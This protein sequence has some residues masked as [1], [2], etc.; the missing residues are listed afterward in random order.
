MHN[1]A[2][3]CFG[4][5]IFNNKGGPDHGIQHAFKQCVRYS[6]HNMAATLID[7]PVNDNRSGNESTPKILMLIDEMES[8]AAGGTERQIL[9]IAALLRA[10]GFETVIATLRGT[11]WLTPEVAGCPVHHANVM[12]LR[13]RSS[14]RELQK[15]QQWMRKERFHIL[16]TFFH[17]SNC[18]GSWLASRAG[19][20]ALVGGRRNLGTTIPLLWKALLRLSNRRV[21]QFHANCEA[22]GQKAIRAEGISPDR[23]HIVYNGIDLTL[24]EGLYQ[25]RRSMR[26]RLGLRPDAIL[27]GMVSGLRPEKGVGD[28]LE[29]ARQMIP[30]AP[31]AH[32]LI[33]GGGELQAALQARVDQHNLHSRIQ[34]VGAQNDVLPYLAAMDV[35]VLSS[36]T[37]GLS[38]SLLEYMAAGL[39]VIATNVGGNREAVGDAGI[40]VPARNPEALAAAMLQM[41]S[42]EW[43]SEFAG[44]SRKQVQRFSLEAAGDRLCSLYSH[45]I[46]QNLPHHFPA[47]VRQSRM[48]RNNG[49][50]AHMKNQNHQSNLRRRR[51]ACIP[52][53]TTRSTELA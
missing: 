49:S 17:E 5:R 35:G 37:E 12:S 14:W 33:V 52:S 25:Y 6:A 2:N 41:Q 40:L 29:A 27:Y 11:A 30:S 45:L 26:Q 31:R 16:T 21:D 7:Q 53:Q 43:R 46:E 15:L 24:F 34:L 42:E 23:V 39:P 1:Q 19:I 18:L 10:G 4:S 50:A 38:N 8:I 36:Y 20:P 51:A 9:Q 22:V 28:F 48:E 44:L 47:S 32:F 3:G 13:S